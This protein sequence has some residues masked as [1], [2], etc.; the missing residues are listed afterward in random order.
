MPVEGTEQNSA[1]E[2]LEL[3]ALPRPV[4]DRPEERNCMNC[5][6][7]FYSEGWHNRLCNQCRKRSEPVG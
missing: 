1:N 3:T 6:T 7:Q 5:G 2:K 4:G